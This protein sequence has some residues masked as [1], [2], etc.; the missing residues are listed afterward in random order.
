MKQGTVLSQASK[1]WASRPD[2][3]RY[4]SLEELRDAVYQRR[5]ESWTATPFV[6]DLRILP[7]QDEGLMMQVYDPTM[8]EIRELAPT[9]WAFTQLAGY[10][11]A[12]AGYMRQIPSELA[13]IN[14]QWGLENNP[15]REGALVLAQSNG[16][17]KL[18]SVTSLS[19]G[20]IWD[21]QVVEAVMKVNQDGRWQIPAASYTT[22]NPRRATT[23]YASDRD[24]FL[25]LVDPDHPIEVE[26][27]T[28]FRGFI[29]W[30]SEVGSSV[31]GLTTFLYRTVCDNRLIWGATNIRELRIRHSGGAPE[32]FAYEGARYLSRYANEDTSQIIEGVIAAKDTEIKPER[33][34]TVADWLKKRGF[35]RP[36]AEASVKAAV[37]EEGSTRTIWDIV[38]GITAHARTI[39][40][41][42]SRVDLETRAGKLM[43]LATG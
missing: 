37:A 40:H 7:T 42:D 24:V 25:F 33:D 10:A 28:L 16:D 34:D 6:K 29:A 41:T 26:G 9:H 19:Y 3:Q 21:S 5:Q 23:L 11:K 27:E 35:T 4:L 32:R 30:N 18:R 13:A 2:D 20:R 12:P 43:K 38:Q 1:E 22:T 39:T 15:M 36:E 17:H 31:F 14:M 8:N